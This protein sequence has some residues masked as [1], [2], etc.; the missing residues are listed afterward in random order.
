LVTFKLFTFGGIKMRL[1]EVVV[2]LLLF[3]FSMLWGLDCSD[4]LFH[5]FD[6]GFY[7]AHD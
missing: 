2:F 7:F 5:F 4:L 6:S 3:V 1:F